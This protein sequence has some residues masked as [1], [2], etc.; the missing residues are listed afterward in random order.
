[1]SIRRV[2]N[3]FI[4]DLHAARKKLLKEYIEWVD[5]G[6]APSADEAW[7]SIVRVTNEIARLEA[8]AAKE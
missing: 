2:R 1:M 5:Y 3:K 4:K 8:E 7:A 6:H